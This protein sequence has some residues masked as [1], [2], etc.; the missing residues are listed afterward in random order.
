MEKVT[1]KLPKLKIKTGD[2]VVVIAGDDKHKKGKVLSVDREKNRAIVEGVN[3]VSKH[4]KP[5]AKN[6]EGGIVTK[7]AYVNIS[8]L[9]IADPKSGKPT[10]VGRKLNSKNKLQ[11]YSKESGDF[12][13]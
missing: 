1:N 7:E 10:K 9:M 6:P 4:L 12:I 8:N 11:R 3:V 2:T 5:S 13:S